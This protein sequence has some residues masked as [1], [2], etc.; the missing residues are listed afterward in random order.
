MGEDPDA[1]AGELHELPHEHHLRSARPVRADPEDAR[2]AVVDHR[3]EAEQPVPVRALRHD[4]SG[5]GSLHEV[6]EL[7]RADGH[8]APIER[9][10]G[11]ELARVAAVRCDRLKAPVVVVEHDARAGRRPDRALVRSRLRDRRL[12]CSIVDDDRR[13]AVGGFA[14]V[15]EPPPVGRPAHVADVGRSLGRRRRVE[16][17]RVVRAEPVDVDGRRAV[18]V[19]DEGNPAG[20]RHRGAPFLGGTRLDPDGRAGR[21]S[22]ERE[23]DAGR[24]PSR[25][26]RFA[27]R[28]ATRRAV[29][30]RR[31]ASRPA[32]VARCRRR[33]R[34]R[35]RRR[36]RTRPASRPASRTRPR[37]SRADAV[38][39]PRG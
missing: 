16:R 38:A 8:D 22:E 3:G 7:R 17:G 28:P 39:S 30:P 1:A 14:R 37:R 10:A 32:A 12:R 5:R 9:R 18:A 36:A 20:A 13:R 31:P 11:A 19:R 29:T 6:G 4:E 27:R 23:S 33:L 15:D 35:G 26:R 24:R 34:A 2:P 25:C 21:Q